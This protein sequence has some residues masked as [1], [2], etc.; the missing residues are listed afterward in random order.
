MQCWTH[1]TLNS[2]PSKHHLE[3]GTTSGILQSLV[4]HSWSE[5]LPRRVST[6]ERTSPACPASTLTAVPLARFHTTASSSP[7]AVTAAPP[8]GASAASAT[9]P[10]W[11]AN[12][13]KLITHDRNAERNKHH[14]HTDIVFARMAKSNFVR[15][16]KLGTGLQAERPLNHLYLMPQGSNNLPLS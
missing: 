10:P 8:P 9:H 11:P 14:V 5:H 7:L 15:I 3:H 12:A 2:L 13:D 16:A 6:T 4:Q 1:S